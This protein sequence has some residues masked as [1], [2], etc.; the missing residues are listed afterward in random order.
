MLPNSNLPASQLQY[1]AFLI[2]TSSHNAQPHTLPCNTTL[3]ATC[4]TPTLSLHTPPP[5]GLTLPHTK[6]QHSIWL[7]P[8][9]AARGPLLSSPLLSSPLLSSRLVLHCT[10]FPPECTNTVAGSCVP[11]GGPALDPAVAFFFYPTARVSR[12]PPHS[13]R[14]KKK[15]EKE[16]ALPPPSVARE[17]SQQ[18]VPGSVQ[19]ARKC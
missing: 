16:K 11:S 18:A 19:H 14:K 1:T 10:V 12:P 4:L 5:A 7:S 15:K 2:P 3:A 17:D 13:H 9:L 8:P 6:A